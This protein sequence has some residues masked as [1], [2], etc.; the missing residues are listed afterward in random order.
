M[1]RDRAH[2][3]EEYNMAKNLRLLSL[4]ILLLIPSLF[5]FMTATALAL[6]WAEVTQDRLLN[7]DK[8]GNN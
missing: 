3:K 7:A 5:F 6:E 1:T 8:E 4:G 2:E